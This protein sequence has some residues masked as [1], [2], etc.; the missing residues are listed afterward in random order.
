MSLLEA[1]EWKSL[2]T[3]SPYLWLTLDGQNVFLPRETKIYDE[4]LA[5]R[6]ERRES[7]EGQ[8]EKETSGPGTRIAR[9]HA[10]RRESFARSRH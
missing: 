9:R 5:F 8:E 1:D 7:T 10:E 6:G 4:L 2:I 3:E